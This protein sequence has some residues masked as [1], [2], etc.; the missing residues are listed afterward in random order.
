MS[1]REPEESQQQPE[2]LRGEGSALRPMEED[3]DPE[4]L[5][6]AESRE[7]GSVLQPLLM[8]AVILV[9]I[10]IL[11]DWREELGYFFSPSEPVE[12]GNVTEFPAR[13]ASTPGWTPTLPH[14]RYV[15]MQGIPTK[16]ASSE[17][18]RFFKL[19]GGQIYVE[20]P[21]E[22][23]IEDPLEREIA[24]ANRTDK[25]KQSE[26]DR[27]YFQGSGRLLSTAFMPER[28][29]GFR[30]YYRARY[31]ITFCEEL[32]AEERAQ[33]AAQR[34]ETVRTNWRKAYEQAS[35]AEREAQGLTPEPTDAELQEILG[36][37]PLC[38]DAFLLQ[39]G[40]SPRDHWWYVAISAAIVL[41]MLFNLVMLGR[42]FYRFFRA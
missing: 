35:A 10:Y 21:R 41:F 31:N 18:Y 39:D 24:E 27:T 6:L 28:Y 13:A 30:T 42:W 7:R 33:L 26:I 34:R 1:Q 9:G 22:D 14:N 20:E 2:E 36:S 8:I 32:T 17:R 40:V 5:E 11:S 25:D 3:I 16:R 29:Q 12:V 19:V 37:E 23:F 4:L 38:V 15:S